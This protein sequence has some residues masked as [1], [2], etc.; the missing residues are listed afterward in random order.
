MNYEARAQEL[1]QREYRMLIGGEMVGAQS[2][3]TY[4]TH[5]P[6]DGRFLANVPYGQ[7]EDVNMAVAAAEAAFPAWSKTPLTERAAKLREFIKVLQDNKIDIGII[8]ALDS[9]NPVTAMIGDVDFSCRLIDYQV[10]IAIEVKGQTLPSMGDN[11]LLTRREPYGVVARI[12]A[13]NHSAL[14][15]AVKFPAPLLMGNTLIIKAPDQDPLPSLLIG[16]LAAKIFPPGVV[17][18]ITGDGSITGDTLVRHPKVKRISL[19]GSVVTGRKVSE[20]AAQA[21]VKHV[22]L[23]LGGKNPIII[24]PDADID[25]V[26][27]GIANGMNCHWSQGQSCGSTTRAFLHE[28]VHDL[29][30]EKLKAR[31]N[32]IRIGNPLNPETQ[33]GCLVSEAQFT[34]VMSYINLGKDEGATLLC[35]GAKPE[36]EQ[37][38]KGYFVQPTVFHD[39][40]MRMRIAQ[41]EIFGPVL[42]VLKWNDIEDVVQQAN[43]VEYGL[44]AS[45][46]TKDLNTA[47]NMAERIEAGYVWINGSGAHFLGAPFGGHKQSGI[48]SEEGIEELYS[49]TQ[50]K[51]VSIGRS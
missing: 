36:G 47:M 28:E 45:I 46:W 34:K 18:I 1:L 24:F 30:L 23:E 41:E 32:K 33:M 39:V 51:T 12:I 22:S 25:K 10:G 29:V 44:T 40:T 35:G 38:E 21:G 15:T 19:I 16:E 48:D 49:F 2:G 13:Y 7:A 3:R 43:S 26:V 14:F 50:I 6:S 9:G 37:F 8:D 11:W 20:A 17:N 4:E 27:E 5:S 31:L 42:S